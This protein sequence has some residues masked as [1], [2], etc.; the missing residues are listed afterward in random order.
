MGKG[1]GEVSRTLMNIPWYVQRYVHERFAQL[2]LKGVVHSL[3]IKAA[4]TFTNKRC[5]GKRKASTSFQ[6]VRLR[7]T[8]GSE[9]VQTNLAQ[10]CKTIGL[11]FRV[12][13]LCWIGFYYDGHYKDVHVVVRHKIYFYMRSHLSRP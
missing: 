6:D 11:V 12:R 7:L 3:F 2:L 8:R 13:A 9:S 10:A 4:C 1:Q 5:A